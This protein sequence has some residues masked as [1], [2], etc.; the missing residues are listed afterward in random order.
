M[1]DKC[2]VISKTFKVQ[3]IY[4]T[5][6]SSRW[7]QTAQEKR[8]LSVMHSLYEATLMNSKL[9]TNLIKI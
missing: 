3:S 5:R 2:V 8:I 1:D 9:V 6:I 7:N 4:K